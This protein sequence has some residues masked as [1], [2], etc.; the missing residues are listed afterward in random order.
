MRSRYPS[1]DIMGGISPSWYLRS[2]YTIAFIRWWIGG[3]HKKY[4][5]LH[6]CTEE[7]ISW[8]LSGSQILESGRGTKPGLQRLCTRWDTYIPLPQSHCNIYLPKIQY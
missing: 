1:L 2:A 3:S 6:G 7:A 8:W 4:P 5:L